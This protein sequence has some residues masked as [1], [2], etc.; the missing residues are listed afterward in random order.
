MT[1]RKIDDY[2]DKSISNKSKSV[3][4]KSGDDEADGEVTHSLRGLRS[5][6]PLAFLAAIGTLRTLAK[7]SEFRT[8][9]LSWEQETSNWTPT[10]RLESPVTRDRLLNVLTTQLTGPTDAIR[11][12]MSKDANHSVGK[13][14]NLNA[15][16]FRE[17]LQAESLSTP[18]E[19]AL[20]AY[21]T[22]AY[23]DYDEIAEFEVRKKGTALTRL[24]VLEFGGPKEYLTSQRKFVNETTRSK[25]RRTLFETW[26]FDDDGSSHRTMHWSPTDASRGAYTGV[27]PTNLPSRT[28]HGAN[29]LA[30]AGSRLYTVVPQETDSAT[31]GFVDLGDRY[32]FQYPIWSSPVALS[33][34][35]TLLTHP[36]IACATPDRKQVHGVTAVLRAEIEINNNY[37]NLGRGVLVG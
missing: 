20:A 33:T 2:S 17:L 31:V 19:R 27:D 5:N 37:R 1:Q 32:V 9:R 16:A 3:H 14:S 24:N 11:Y 4:D 13:L 7:C 30:I 12:V 34:I 15:V 10:I 21:A 18:D 36:D 8:P 25:L 23:V 35:R 22:D 26:D 28:M 6:D 29:R